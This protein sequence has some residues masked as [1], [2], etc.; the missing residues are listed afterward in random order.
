MGRCWVGMGGIRL[1]RRRGGIVVMSRSIGGG[2]IIMGDGVGGV[3]GGIIVVVR[4]R[5][6]GD[7]GD[8]YAHRISW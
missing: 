3:E 1:R 6:R 2:M 5:G 7:G 4:V 8:D